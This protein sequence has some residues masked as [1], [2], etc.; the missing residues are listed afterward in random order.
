MDTGSMSKKK[1]RI[2]NIRQTDKA[3]PH[4]K[5]YKIAMHVDLI[6]R[7]RNNNKHNIK[8]RKRSGR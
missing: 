7:A 5:E 8:S 2:N 6:R 1:Q 3:D 4:K